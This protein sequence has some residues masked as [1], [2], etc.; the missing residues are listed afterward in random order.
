LIINSV[1]LGLDPRVQGHEHFCML[2]LDPRV[3]REDDDRDLCD[4]QLI[5]QGRRCLNPANIADRYFAC[6]R[7]R[8]LAGLA[9]LFA[10]DAAF[11]LPDG[12]ELSGAAAIH[13]MY[14]NLFDAQ[15]PSPRPLATIVGANGVATEIETRLADGTV[16]RTAN[17]FHLDDKGRIK[18][19]SVYTRTG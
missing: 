3:K 2:L 17:F 16:R 1:T 9:A 15:A 13:G 14:A 11:I 18:R 6:M 4:R 12:R 19:L 5:T 7:G 8:D 10:D